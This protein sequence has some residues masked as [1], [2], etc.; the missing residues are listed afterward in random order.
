MNKSLWLLPLALLLLMVWACSPKAS[1]IPPP[2]VAI[3][4]LVPVISTTERSIHE[5]PIFTLLIPSLL[6]TLD[7]SGFTYTLFLGP[8][9]G[10]AMYD[11]EANLNAI[12]RK[13]AEMTKDFPV[14]LQVHAMTGN[15]GAPCWAW[16]QLASLAFNQS[17]DYLYQ[18]NDDLYMETAG[19]ASEFVRELRRNDNVGVVGPMDSNHAPI[20]TQ[21]F[22]HRTHYDIF[23]S[24]FPVEFR[25]WYS[26]DWITK[27]Y[28]VGEMRKLTRIRVRNGGSGQRYPKH[29][30]GDLVPALVASG[31]RRIV[32]YKQAHGKHTVVDLWFWQRVWRGEE[33]LL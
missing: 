22:V 26:D 5:L 6:E 15:Q 20:L 25:N 13:F 14:T 27:V 21:S 10:D 29:M 9:K 23:R 28:P 11:T 18:V 2:V 19:W 17:F 30:V 12:R 8:D 16:N 3:A 33:T 32:E 31:R 1:E 4:L 7:D 24:Y